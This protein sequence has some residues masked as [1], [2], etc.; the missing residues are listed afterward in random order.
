MRSRGQSL[1]GATKASLSGNKF[2]RGVIEDKRTGTGCTVTPACCVGATR[3]AKRPTKIMYAPQYA[4]WKLEER[5]HL[6]LQ[7]DTRASFEPAVWYSRLPSAAGATDTAASLIIPAIFLTPRRSTIL[8][9]TIIT[10]NYAKL[11]H[12]GC[13]SPVAFVALSSP[14]PSTIQLFSRRCRL[15]RTFCRWS[16]EN[17]GTRERERSHGFGG[18]ADR[19]QGQLNRT[20]GNKSD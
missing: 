9:V 19:P 3:R 6:S 7:A 2:G 16:M 20:A 15:G 8:R 13:T 14:R 5:N 11:P 18:T 17:R 10:R 1:A 4:Q 12:G